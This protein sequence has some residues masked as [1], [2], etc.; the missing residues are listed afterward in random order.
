MLGTTTLFIVE[1]PSPP[2]K[3]KLMIFCKH[4]CMREALELLTLFLLECIRFNDCND[5]LSAIKL[6][7]YIN[8]SCNCMIAIRTSSKVV[9][10]ESVAC[11]P[12]LRIVQLFNFAVFTT[13]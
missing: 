2:E 12:L 11:H 3:K 6:F 9:G 4:E 1:P 13:L 7:T 5:Y 8:H 10:A